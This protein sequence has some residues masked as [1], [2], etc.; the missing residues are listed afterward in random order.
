MMVGW[1]HGVLNFD[2]A[3]GGIVESHY[4][5]TKNVEYMLEIF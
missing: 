3:Q 5:T 4:S 1:T 2:L